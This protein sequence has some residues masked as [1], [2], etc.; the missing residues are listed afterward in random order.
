KK[1]KV[2]HITGITPA[3]SDTCRELVM[4]AITIA[5]KTNTTIR[6]DPNIRLKLW[7]KEEASETLIPIASQCD[8]F[9]PG[10]REMKHLRD[11]AT[12]EE[13]TTQ[14]MECQITITVMKD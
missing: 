3:L 5:K 14:I 11:V 9:L 1:A 12:S 13:M 7:T 8:V 2:L 10:Q 4:E 6:F